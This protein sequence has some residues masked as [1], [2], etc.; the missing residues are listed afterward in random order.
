MTG[1]DGA[2]AAA[3][4]ALAGDS[5]TALRLADVALRTQDGPDRLLGARVLAAVLPQRG[6]LARAAE[7]HRWLARQG[8]GTPDA[9]VSLL[10]TGALAEARAALAPAAD[11]LPGLRDGADALLAQG[12]LASVDGRDGS[13]GTSLSLLVRA[14]TS[15]AATGEQVPAA[16]SP[17]A[18]GALLALHRGEPELAEPLLDLAADADLGGPAL[19]R[20]HV[21]LRAW[22]AMLRDDESAARAA[23]TAADDL[24]GTPE[25]RDALVTVACEVALARH[26]GDTRRLLD[27]WSRARQALLRHPV[28]LYSLLPVGELAIAAARLGESRWVEPHLAEATALL[29][30]L[31]DPPS[32]STSWHWARLHAAITA[33]D[34]TGAGA[35]ATALETAA[36]VNDRAVAPARAARVWLAVLAGEVDADAVNAAATAL[37][38][39]GLGRDGARLAGEAA[40]RTT[41]RADS[42]A[43]L[44]CARTLQAGRVPTAPAPV[45]VPDAGSSRAVAVTRAR[46][47]A[48]LTDRERDIAELVLE[49]LTYREIAGRLFLSTKTVEHHVA[50]IRRRLG[51][52][53]RAEL[54][55]ELKVLVGTAP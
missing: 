48:T 22:S 42:A 37:R 25:A 12:L 20:R 53:S 9:V 54:F 15:L 18:I 8:A 2:T 38:A 5:D 50:R 10:G 43:L 17:A 11:V 16:D 26:A 21:L 34:H 31:G 1:P 55:S 28:D 39:V 4:A 3:D 13:A 24:P 7:V 23:L 33:E 47:E 40:I 6:L 29:A 30:S 36:L 41:D 32:W 49:G 44:A 35:H 19:R 45:P 46:R 52:E 14:T 51:S 27:L